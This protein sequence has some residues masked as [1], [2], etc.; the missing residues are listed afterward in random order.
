M[1]TRPWV[2]PEKRL[3][4]AKSG[5]YIMPQMCQTID[6]SHLIRETKADK[7]LCNWCNPDT[8]YGGAN[9]KT[10]T[11]EVIPENLKDALKTKTAKPNN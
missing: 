7:Y 1:F 8:V 10:S 9:D 11:G 3:R 5:D 4:L 6:K 2:L